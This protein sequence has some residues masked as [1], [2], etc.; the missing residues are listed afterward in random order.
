MAG[1]RLAPRIS[2]P[3]S[4][5]RRGSVRLIAVTKFSEETVVV[6]NNGSLVS[7]SARVGKGESAGASE[8]HE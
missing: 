3:G 2:G 6:Y 8:K 4:D 7:V 5:A 1:R